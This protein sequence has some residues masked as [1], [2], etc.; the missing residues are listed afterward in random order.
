MPLEIYVGVRPEI[1][2]CF[3]PLQPIKIK[4]GIL[5]TFLSANERMGFIIFP[6][7]NFEDILLVFFQFLN[8]I[9]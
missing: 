2:C 5:K 9:L 7:L 1:Y 8:D 4:M 3:P 6:I